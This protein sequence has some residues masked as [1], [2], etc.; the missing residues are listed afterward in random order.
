VDN[1]IF[2]FTIPEQVETS[3]NH[4]LSVEVERYLSEEADNFIYIYGEYDTWS[5][6]GITSTGSTNSRIF[7]KEG[8]SHRTRINNMPDD[9]RMEVF[10]TLVEFLQ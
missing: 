8:G 5:A 9:Q 1:P 7:I 6:T 3:Y 4:D 2:T 10:N